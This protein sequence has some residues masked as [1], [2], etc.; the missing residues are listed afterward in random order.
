MFTAAGVAIGRLIR[1]GGDPYNADSWAQEAQGA[2]FDAFP[3]PGGGVTVKF[4][5]TRY[6][7][8]SVER[9]IAN[10]GNMR[11]CC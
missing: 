3:V 6:V 7:S 11:A 2:L 9:P 1:L 8:K 5:S 4:G 10:R